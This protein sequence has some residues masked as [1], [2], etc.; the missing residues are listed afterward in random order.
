MKILTVLEVIKGC[1]IKLILIEK[2]SVAKMFCNKKRRFKL[3]IYV[4]NSDSKIF[5]SYMESPPPA[6]FHNKYKKSRAICYSVID[7]VYIRLTLPPIISDT[8]VTGPHLASSPVDVSLHL[9]W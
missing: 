7:F 3:L 4:H 2:M 6:V 5:L 8:L 9:P 1:E